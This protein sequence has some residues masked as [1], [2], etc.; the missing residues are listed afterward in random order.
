MILILKPHVNAETREYKQLEGHL[1]RLNN[2]DLECIA[3]K[4]RSKL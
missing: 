1:S 4:A 2:I 3:F